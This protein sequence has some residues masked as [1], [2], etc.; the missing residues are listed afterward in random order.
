VSFC[1]G[2]MAKEDHRQLQGKYTHKIGHAVVHIG[3]QV[4]KCST[5]SVVVSDVSSCPLSLSANICSYA[6]V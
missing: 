3:H 1:A 4:S 5:R 6:N 2:V